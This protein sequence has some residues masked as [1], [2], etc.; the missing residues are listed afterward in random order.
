MLIETCSSWDE[1]F[2]QRMIDFKMFV[3]HGIVTTFAE[4]ISDYEKFFSEKSPFKDDYDW[5]AFIVTKDSII[6]SKAILC[7]RKNETV[8][9]LGFIDWINNEEAAKFLVDSVCAEGR[10][11]GT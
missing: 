7:W 8:G 5:K 2:F 6:L 9:N 4:T 11:R 3:H 10:L 1:S